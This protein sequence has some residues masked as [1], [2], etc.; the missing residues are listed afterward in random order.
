[1]KSRTQAI[2]MSNYS[3]KLPLSRN[4]ARRN[5]N[6]NNQSNHYA[7]AEE[8]HSSRFSL[9]EEGD[10]CDSDAAQKFEFEK[11]MLLQLELRESYQK[12]SSLLRK[13]GDM[14][15][16]AG[17]NEPVLAEE[18]PKPSVQ[19]KTSGKNRNF[20]GKQ[21]EIRLGTLAATKI[22]NSSSSSSNILSIIRPSQQLMHYGN[23]V[24]TVINDNYY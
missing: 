11:Q 23:N 13:S 14:A 24:K 5:K 22:K 8:A 19:S 20:S 9:F 12:K 6:I 4:V 1:M 15:T 7:I 10:S 21:K 18:L 2:D 16:F 3:A 17:L